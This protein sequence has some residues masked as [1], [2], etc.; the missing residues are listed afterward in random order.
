[1]PLAET[2]DEFLKF[3][4]RK[5]FGFDFDGRSGTIEEIIAEQKSWY[6]PKYM[7][8]QTREQYEKEV[9][10]R[11]RDEKEWQ[12]R[13]MFDDDSIEIMNQHFPLAALLEAQK[14]PA[15]P[16]YLQKNLALAI[17]TRAVLLNDE[18]SAQKIAPE[19]ARLAPEFAEFFAVYRNAK[20]P[21]ARRRAA[22]F[23]ILKNP[24]FTPYLESGIGK[25]DNEFNEWDID[26]WWCAP[27]E[28]VYDEATGSEKPRPIPARPA[29]LTKLQSDAAQAERKRLAAIGDAPKFWGETFLEWARLAPN[30]KRVPEGLYVAYR[31]NG[32]TKYGCGNNIELRDK[33]GNFMKKRY[34]QNEWTLKLDEER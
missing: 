14:S 33:I 9:E 19:V 11:Y 17:W 18:V 24:V 10:E 21:L 13:T 22:L 1:M 31:A 28:T 27:Y 26:D 3:A 8:E 16:E 15:L 34:P 6:D 7:T 30:D 20:T 32:W 2:L 29:F 25:Q 12:E 5:P 4:Q 23:T